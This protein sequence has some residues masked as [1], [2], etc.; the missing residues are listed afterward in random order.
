MNGKSIGNPFGGVNLDERQRD[1][2]VVGGD[3]RTRRRH[4]RGR[5]VGLPVEEP[6]ERRRPRGSVRSAAA[7]IDEPPE[8]DPSTVGGSGSTDFR[9]R[10][11]ARCAD[12][13]ADPGDIHSPW[14]IEPSA[15][16]PTVASWPT[17]P[18]PDW[19]INSP[20]GRTPPSR[21][22]CVHTC[23]TTTWWSTC[24]RPRR[25]SWRWAGR[26]SPVVPA[27]PLGLPGDPARPRAGYAREAPG[28]AEPAARR[29]P[30][31]GGI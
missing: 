23:C 1:L 28:A 20:T 3:P 11:G 27:G 6:R 15:P 24:R 4:R 31:P 21:G 2:G 19:P 9:R 12:E 10:R 18:G 17:T 26:R 16:S 7:E 22:R 25:R 8:T 13:R 14:S 30:E 5:A 29:G